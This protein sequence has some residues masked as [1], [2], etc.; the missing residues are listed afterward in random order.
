MYEGPR[1]CLAISL[2]IAVLP[3]PDG[4]EISKCGGFA[5]NESFSMLLITESGNNKS[6]KRNGD[7][8]SNQDGMMSVE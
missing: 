1:T 7:L 4:P 8:V 3:T 2:H 6:W 5:C